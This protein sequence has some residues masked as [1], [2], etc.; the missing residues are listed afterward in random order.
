MA[1]QLDLDSEKEMLSKILLTFA[2]HYYLVVP[3]RYEW[4][5]R[6]TIFP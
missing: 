6:F 2:I 3:I 4:G 5:P 1:T